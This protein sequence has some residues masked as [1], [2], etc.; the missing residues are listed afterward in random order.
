[1]STASDILRSIEQRAE[2]AIAHELWQMIEQILGM[3]TALVLC[4]RAHADGLLMKLDNLIGSQASQ[5][6][7]NPAPT[8][9]R[10]PGFLDDLV[11]LSPSDYEVRFYDRQCGDLDDVAVVE[12]FPLAVQLVADRFAP[13]ARDRTEVAWCDGRGS[14]TVRSQRGDALVCIQAIDKPIPTIQPFVARACQALESGDP[15]LA[16]QL[17]TA[18]RQAA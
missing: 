8:P 1:M 14:L 3:R 10:T 9:D 5:A 18:V 2:R 17:F 15:S 4:D 12:S 7:S 6:A 16:Q 11:L 13:G